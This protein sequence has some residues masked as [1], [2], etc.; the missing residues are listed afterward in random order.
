MP[1]EQA[2]SQQGW[3]HHICSSR[4]QN[5]KPAHAAIDCDHLGRKSE[6]LNRFSHV[7][8]HLD[9]MRSQS[10]CSPGIQLSF[11]GDSIASLSAAIYALRRT[12][13]KSKS[14]D[15]TTTTAMYSLRCRPVQN[16]SYLPVILPIDF[17]VHA[18]IVQR[19]YRSCHNCQAISSLVSYVFACYA[20]VLICVCSVDI[21]FLG[22]ENVIL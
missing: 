4:A 1:L 3:L 9:Y 2:L 16:C 22:D 14:S 20:A 21:V 6:R 8:F 15:R 11:A 12:A 17:I 7:R 13:L 10:V 5:W 19:S 18:L